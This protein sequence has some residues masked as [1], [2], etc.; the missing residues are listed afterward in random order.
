MSIP[1][2]ME[3]GGAGPGMFQPEPFD[4]THTLAFALL[5]N[6][7]KPWGTVERS[8]DD[9]CHPQARLLRV[10]LRAPSIC[11]LPLL[12]SLL[13]FSFPS[14]FPSCLPSF[15]SFKEQGLEGTTTACLGRVCTQVLH[16][17]VVSGPRECGPVGFAELPDHDLPDPARTPVLWRSQ[18]LRFLHE[19]PG[20]GNECGACGPGPCHRGFVEVLRPPEP[21]SAP[22]PQI[23]PFSPDSTGNLGDGSFGRQLPRLGL[24]SQSLAQCQAG[25]NSCR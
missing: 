4:G 21:A 7:Y 14:L 12:F 22:P 24:Y 18:G 19:P 25:S 3:T 9:R 6:S 17:G 1:L 13:P 11:S 10:P 23:S 16:A 20:R 8:T 2:P 5:S 15:L